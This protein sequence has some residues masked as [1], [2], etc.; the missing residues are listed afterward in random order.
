MS[1]PPDSG[2]IQVNL[3]TQMTRPVEKIEGS[4]TV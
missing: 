3:D 1:A 4:D 2:M